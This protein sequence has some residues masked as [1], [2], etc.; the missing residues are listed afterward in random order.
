MFVNHTRLHALQKAKPFEFQRIYEGEVMKHNPLKNLMG[1]GRFWLIMSA[2]LVVSTYYF[3]DVIEFLLTDPPVESTVNFESD[4]NINVNDVDIEEVAPIEAVTQEVSISPETNEGQGT[5]IVDILS[6]LH[7]AG[8]LLG[9]D[10]IS[11]SIMLLQTG[12]DQLAAE[13]S[14][15]ATFERCEM[16][17][18][19]LMDDEVIQLKLRHEP[20]GV[21][22][23]WMTGDRG[24]EILYN[25]QQ[26]DGRML[27]R[28]GGLK[29]RILPALKLDPFGSRAMGKSR[30]P[31][32]E[33]GLLSLCRKLIDYRQCDLAENKSIDCRLLSEASCD[34]KSSYFLN[35]EYANRDESQT[36]RK[37]RLHIDRETLLPVCIWN[38]TWPDSSNT[39]VDDD[40]TLIEYYHYTDL[41]MGEPFADSDFSSANPEYGFGR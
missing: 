29:G 1:R 35:L 22:M 33:S 27:V 17:N 9:R 32:T 4:G 41:S 10:A 34:D 11:A 6:T 5:A 19:H 31:I 26:L 2:V 3:D 16:V 14:Y 36:Y 40:S 25:N 18:G 30:Y 20:F 39:Q 12:H 37:T 28:L 23:K 21:Y 38:Y 15:A 24:R 7:T 13:P 8:E